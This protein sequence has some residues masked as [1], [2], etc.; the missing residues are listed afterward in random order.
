VLK[1]FFYSEH[2]QGTAGMLASATGLGVSFV[3]PLEI[4]L[5]ILSLLIGITVG[6][7]TLRNLLR[8]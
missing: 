7:V 5:R 2:G 1:R 8:K 3:S 4:S 6:L